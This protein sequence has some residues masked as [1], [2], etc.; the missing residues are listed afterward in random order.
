MR[1]TAIGV[2]YVARKGELGGKMK[3]VPYAMFFTPQKNWTS[4]REPG[5]AV[6]EA[7]S[8]V[9]TPSIRLQCSVCMFL[10]IIAQL[11]RFN[12]VSE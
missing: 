4:I 5:M 11:S 1:T 12:V 8:Q 10:S 6:T 2:P 9:R 7:S 3:A